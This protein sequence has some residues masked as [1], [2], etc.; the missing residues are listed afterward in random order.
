VDDLDIEDV[1][2][3]ANAGDKL[4]VDVIKHVAIYLGIGIANLINLFNPELVVLGGNIIKVKDIIRPI[5]GDVVER[6]ALE[7]TYKGCRLDISLLGD[8]AT[9]KGAYALI[10]NRLFGA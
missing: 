5:L 8:D 9:I 2:S 6:R 7:N 3:A 1:Y 10:L 4:A